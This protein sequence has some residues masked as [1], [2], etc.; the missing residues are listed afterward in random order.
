M[1][2]GMQRT[3]TMV[4]SFVIFFSFVVLVVQFNSLK[5]TS[6]ILGY[7]PLCPAGIVL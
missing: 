2:A 1:M 3:L 6:L 5:L 4:L 7:A